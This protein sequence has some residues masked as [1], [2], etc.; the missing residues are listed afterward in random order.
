M[1][2][3]IYCQDCAKTSVYHQ[4]FEGEFSHETK[5]VMNTYGQLC[6]YCCCALE[7]GDRASAF[8]V[9]VGSFKPEYAYWATSYMDAE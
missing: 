9:G 7:Q 5:G 3:E 2:N 4:D 6:D 1:K 8:T